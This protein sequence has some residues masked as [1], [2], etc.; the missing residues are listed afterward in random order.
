MRSK[1]FRVIM[2]V[3]PDIA[4]LKEDTVLRVKRLI[5]SPYII[6]AG[7]FGSKLVDRIGAFGAVSISGNHIFMDV[8]NADVTTTE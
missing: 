3:F 4:T 1:H 5:T 6:K 2:R 7:G 8:L